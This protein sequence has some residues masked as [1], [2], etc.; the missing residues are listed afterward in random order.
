MAS[1]KHYLEQDLDD[2]ARLILL[3][4]RE[5]IDLTKFASLMVETHPGIG[6]FM[7]DYQ[8]RKWHGDDHI[9]PTHDYVYGHK[10]PQ[11]Y[12]GLRKTT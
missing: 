5:Y 8:W 12:T 3:D 6:R 4:H 1:L 7:I 9:K 11:E 10:F 2:T